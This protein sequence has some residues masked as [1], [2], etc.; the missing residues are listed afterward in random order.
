MIEQQIGILAGNHQIFCDLVRKLQLKNSECVYVHDPANFMGKWFDRLI[1]TCLFW[2][3]K[4][5]GELFKATVIRLKPGMRE[6]YIKCCE[7]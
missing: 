3:R 5:A 7:E 2:Q 4:D 6:E 1:I